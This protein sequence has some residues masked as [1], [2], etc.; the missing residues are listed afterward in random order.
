MRR[1]A[2]TSGMRAPPRGHRRGSL[3]GLRRCATPVT[4]ETTSIRRRGFALTLVVLASVV[5]F[6][7]IFSVWINRQALNTDNWT[8]TSSRLLQQPVIRARVAGFLIDQLYANVDVQ[9]EIRSALPPRFQALAGPAAGGLRNLAEQGTRE[10]LARPRAQLAW[11]NANRQAHKLLVKVLEGGGSTV[12]TNNGKVVLDLKELLRE[13]EAR[14][15]VGG[16]LA[17]QLPASAAQI[18]ILRSDQLSTAQ[19]VFKVLRPL[20]I[21]LVGLSLLLFAVALWIAP[22]WRRRAVR[23][24]G[25]G[26]IAAGALALA[27]VALLGDSVVDS[28]ARTAAAEP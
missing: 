14:V 11:E 13:T 15:G 4:M 27:A 22:D 26:F 17:A 2:S 25:V 24:Y 23:A 6:V 20:P 28:L 3:R 10:L 5:A 16:R 9:G 1:G 8:A 19:S 21:V 12:S 18:T 7:A